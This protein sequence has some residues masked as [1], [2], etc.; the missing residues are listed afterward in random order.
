MAA[1]ALSFGSPSA[2]WLPVRLELEGEALEFVAS[3]SVE[4]PIE[5]LCNS[6]LDVATG[7]ESK[8]E[9]FLEPDYYEF[10]FSPANGQVVFEVNLVE[11]RTS[12]LRDLPEKRSRALSWIGPP[13]SIV[14]SFWRALKKLANS[15]MSEKEWPVFPTKLLAQLEDRAR[16][17]KN[18]G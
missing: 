8:T 7:R 17:Y 18:E 3:D 1:P 9:W 5:Q 4:D 16:Q 13:S 2:G 6:L 12:S 15:G 11:R 14:T 10:S